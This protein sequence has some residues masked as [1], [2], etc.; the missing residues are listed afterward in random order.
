MKP[1]PFPYKYRQSFITYVFISLNIHS[2][3]KT[4]IPKGIGTLQKYVQLI[5]ISINFLY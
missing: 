4:Y 1:K 5:Y 3:I 2:S